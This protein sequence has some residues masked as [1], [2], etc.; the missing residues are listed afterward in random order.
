M[1]IRRDGADVAVHNDVV[2]NFD[3]GPASIPTYSLADLR[4]CVAA[5]DTAFFERN[6]SGKAVLLGTVLDVEDRLPT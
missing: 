1:T 3:Q 4:R 6:F 2:V 5:G